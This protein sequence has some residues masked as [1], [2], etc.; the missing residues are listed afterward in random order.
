MSRPHDDTRPLYARVTDAI[1]A[2][3]EHGVR[4]WV[5]PWSVEHAAGA[6]T[7]PLRHNLEPYRG[8]NVVLLWA[9]ATARGYAAPVW[10]TFRQALTLGGCVRRG[11]RGVTV[12]YADRI[13]RS[14]ADG[15]EAVRSIPFLK[16][17][18]VFNREQIDGLP[19]MPAPKEAA[20]APAEMRIAHAEAFFAA[21]GA[22][23]RHGGA[24]AFYAMGP[25]YVQTPPIGAFGEAEAYYATLAHE[26]VH[27]A[28]VRIMPRQRCLRLQ[29]APTMSA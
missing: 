7:R 12:V 19:D 25:D 21:T 23:I 16:A 13:Q 11:E 10:M 1:I 4:P 24:Q 9:E 26:C 17:Y 20:P 22:E 29:S 27:N 18:T 28:E 3:L 14:E 6:V 8:I 2:D 5:K 15:D